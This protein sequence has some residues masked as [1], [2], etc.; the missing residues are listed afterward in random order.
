M[1]HHQLRGPGRGQSDD[2]DLPGP[3]RHGHRCLRGSSPTLL[4]AKRSYYGGDGTLGNLGTFG[5]L[6]S[7]GRVTATQ[8]ATTSSTGTPGG[9]QTTAAMSY[10]GAG[11][12][13][14]SL[15]AKGNATTSA[16]TPVWTTAGGNTDP[17]KEVST[18]PQGWTTTSVLD[19]L[20]GL[21]TEN[22]DANGGETDITYDA[23]GRRTAVWLPGHT[24]S[25]YPSLPD[26]TFSYSIDPGAVAA[27]GGTV[28]S[29]GAPSS[30]TTNTL[31][32]GGSYATSVTIYDGM[33]QAR[34]TQT[35]PQGDSNQGR[36]ISDTFYD[37]HGWPR[38][39]YSTYSEPDNPRPPP[40]TRLT[41]TRSPLR[42]RP[43][44]T[45]RGGRPPRSCSARVLSSG[46]PPPATQVRTRPT[47]ARSKI[48]AAM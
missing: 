25:A 15:D 33:L 3:E 11:R 27:P 31:L 8:T 26:E 42:T 5:Q 28:T 4:S 29:P 45:A 22:I 47:P 41:R 23:L 39:T 6:D 19:P 46:S 20:R 9:W 43:S 40:C 37:S 7:T 35:S 34:Q 32:E 13:L 2:A 18:N 17:T 36:L 1:Q 12:V 44:T 14:K 10:D 21:A 24:Q 16:F 38:V 48:P 30:V